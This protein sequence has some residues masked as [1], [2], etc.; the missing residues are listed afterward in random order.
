MDLVSA[1][2]IDNM[3]EGFE[4][5][6]R[7]GDGEMYLVLGDCT[8]VLV[9]AIGLLELVFSGNVLHLLDCFYVP[10][11]RGNLILVQCIGR[12]GYTIILN[13]NILIK[14]DKLFIYYVTIMNG[15]C[16]FFPNNYNINNSKVE[17]SK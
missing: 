17:K 4:D 6:R 8:R 3:L 9:K 11:V 10:A 16:F 1:N 2:Y 14:K 12:N 7:L 5:T 13:D 15:L